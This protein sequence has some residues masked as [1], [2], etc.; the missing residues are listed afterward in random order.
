MCV[1][2]STHEEALD[3]PGAEVQAVIAHIAWVLGVELVSFAR[4]VEVLNLLHPSVLKTFFSV[5]C[6]FFFFLIACLQFFISFRY[7]MEK[8]QALKL[9]LNSL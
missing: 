9:D 5:F 1:S 8:K 3:P 4:V 2:T 6:L 7:I